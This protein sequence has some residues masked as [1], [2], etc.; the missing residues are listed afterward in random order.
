M[1]SH[2]YFEK[3]RRLRW[4]KDIAEDYA[5]HINLMES[6]RDHYTIHAI[7]YSARGEGRVFQINS[8]FPIPAAALYEGLNKALWEVNEEITALTEELKCPVVEL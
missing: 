7:H 1:K 6:E 4:L 8:H 5:K 3:M 2:E